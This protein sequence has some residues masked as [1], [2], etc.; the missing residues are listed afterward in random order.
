M[1]EV[2]SEIEDIGIKAGLC[3]EIYYKLIVI[4]FDDLLKPIPKSSKKCSALYHRRNEAGNFLLGN[5]KAW[6][7]SLEAIC[8]LIDFDSVKIKRAASKLDY[9]QWCTIKH[10][11]T[12]Y[13]GTNDEKQRRPEVD[14]VVMDIET[15]ALP[16]QMAIQAS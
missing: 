4:S 13:F 8:E 12:G 15:Q 7:A 14:K 1:S 11:M 5:S 3:K 16:S 2:N 10:N 9:K 6:D